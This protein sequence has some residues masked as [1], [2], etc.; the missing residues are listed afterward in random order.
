ME[1]GKAS[2]PTSEHISNTT[3]L[4]VTMQAGTPD[5]AMKP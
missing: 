2:A 4:F 3:L 5:K 1:L